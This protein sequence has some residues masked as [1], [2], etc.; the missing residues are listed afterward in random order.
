MMNEKRREDMV[1]RIEKLTR[2]RSL[3]GATVLEIGADADN[4]SAQLLLDA[5]AR[6]VIS[7]NYRPNWPNETNGAIERRHVDARILPDAF[8][9]QSIDIVFGVAVLEHINGLAEFFAGSAKVLKP[10]GLF[11]VHGGPIWSSSKGHHVFVKGEAMHY[12]FGVPDANPI[13]NWAHLVSTVTTLAE[14]LVAK[15]IPRG[16]AEKIGAY[17]YEGEEINRVGYRTMCETFLASPLKLIEQRDNAF[18][19]PPDDLLVAIE[20][21]CFGGQQRYDVSGITF[22]AET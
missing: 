17:V 19:S 21:G 18:D 13:P 4:I 3:A 11:H 12:R 5:G 16:D 22:V 6:R 2:Y 14:L 20:H 8:E 10:G 15:G 9:G 1:R 7:T